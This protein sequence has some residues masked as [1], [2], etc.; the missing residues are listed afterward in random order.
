MLK[1]CQTGLVAGMKATPMDPTFTEQ[2][3]AI[4]QAVLAF[5]GR[6]DDFA[7]LA[8]G[9]AKRGLGVAAKSP[10]TSSGDF[11]EAV[12]NFD[13]KGNLAFVDV[14]IDDKAPGTDGGSNACESDGILDKGETG[15]LTVRLQNSRMGEADPDAGQGDDDRPEHHVRQRRRGQRPRRWTRTRPR[16]FR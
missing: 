14:A 9:F 15:T 5:P 16:R 10:P 13:M 3:N 11:N 4:L 6:A 1:A 8:K 2:R 12:E 7:A